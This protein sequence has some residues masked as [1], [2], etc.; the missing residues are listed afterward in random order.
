MD[1]F[2]NGPETMRNEDKDSAE[3]G[4]GFK[5][6]AHFSSGVVA[7]RFIGVTQR[8]LRRLASKKMDSRR[9]VR[10]FVHTA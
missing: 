6:A 8:R 9:P 4:E 10:Q 1:K 2:P 5:S 7:V 3:S